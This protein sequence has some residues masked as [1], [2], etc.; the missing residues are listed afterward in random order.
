MRLWGILATLALLLPLLLVGGALLLNRLPLN[1]P[2]GLWPRLR[3]YLGS[4]LA[5][6]RPDH[7]FPE[8]RSRSYPLPA[9]ELHLKLAEAMRGLG[10]QEIS[11]DPQT[12]RVEAVVATPLFGFRDDLL[13]QVQAVTEGRSLLY[14]RSA[15]RVGRGDLGANTRHLLDLYQALAP[16]AA[17]GD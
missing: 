4:N 6:T 1:D 9:R 16:L 13:A 7:P 11:S 12:L 17:G 10:W 8:L 3:V 14:L 15:S 5:E 2:P